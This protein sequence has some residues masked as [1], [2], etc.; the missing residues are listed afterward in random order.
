MAVAAGRWR[1]GGGGGAVAWACLDCVDG[2]P[3]LRRILVAERVLP[4]RMEDAA[5]N[6]E[7]VA[8]CGEERGRAG[9][10]QRAGRSRRS[11]AVKGAVVK[12]AAH[13]MH[14]LPSGYTL[15]CQKSEVILR[16]GGML[17]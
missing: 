12:G 13:E 8:P 15:G 6:G 7:G 14:T 16:V 5:S 1:R 17:G 4:R 9:Q 11:R 2:Q 10:A 3:T